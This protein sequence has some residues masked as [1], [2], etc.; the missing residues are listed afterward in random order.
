MISIC[1]PVYNFVVVDT[2]NALLKEADQRNLDVEIILFDD[3]SMPYYEQQNRILRGRPEVKYLPLI[4][5]IGRSRIRNRMADLATGDWLLFMDCDMAPC[6]STFLKKYADMTAGDYDVVCGG[7]YTGERPSDSQLMLRWRFD[8]LRA[9]H[10]KWLLQNTDRFLISA[11]NF[12][13]RREVY[14]HVRFSESLTGYGQEDQL[15]A[16]ELASAGSTAIWIDNPTIHLGEEP[17]EEFFAKIE[18]SLVNL[19]RVWNANPDFHREMLRTSKRLKVIYT[20]KRLRLTRPLRFLFRMVKGRLRSYIL[21]GRRSMTFF[22][23]YQSGYLMEVFSMPNLNRLT[24]GALRASF[25][26]SIIH[27]IT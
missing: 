16:L 24:T 17:N 22:S 25:A 1:L 26:E 15:F 12:M 11:G 7:V 14:Q 10:Q 21:S 3:H 13:V 4:E 19:V 5:N 9:K 6:H 23:M 2:V 8:N 18:Q 20:L 27:D